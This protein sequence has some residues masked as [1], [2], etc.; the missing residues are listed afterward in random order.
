MSKKWIRNKIFLCRRVRVRFCSVYVTKHNVYGKWKFVLV[1]EVNASSKITVFI[2]SVREY[3]WVERTQVNVFMWLRH[4]RF[5]YVFFSLGFV[6]FTSYFG[7]YLISCVTNRYVSTYTFKFQCF[8]TCRHTVSPFFFYEYRASSRDKSGRSFVP[9]YVVR[10]G[11]R[12]GRDGH[13]SQLKLVV[14]T[15]WLGSVVEFQYMLYVSVKKWVTQVGE[16]VYLC[17]LSKIV[18]WSPSFSDPQVTGVETKVNVVGNPT[19]KYLSRLFD[20]VRLSED[21]GLRTDPGFDSL[22][23]GPSPLLPHS[24]LRLPKG[25]LIRIQ[26][27]VRRQSGP[28]FPSHTTRDP[29]R[30]PFL[31]PRFGHKGF[32]REFRLVTYC[33]VHPPWHWS[34]L[35]GGPNQLRKTSLFFLEYLTSSLCHN[36][37]DGFQQTELGCVFSWWVLNSIFLLRCIITY[38]F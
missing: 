21:V 23:L 34:V 12:S 14:L 1:L 26:G 31:S 38:R 24:R 8:K 29:H 5:T 9:P 37:S 6:G 4:L 19:S 7:V 2:I 11:G 33:G 25:S 15:S 36:D 20:G 28:A 32:P 30:Y 3:K 35:F 18:R 22:F 27:R 13:L 16:W 10:V 17:L